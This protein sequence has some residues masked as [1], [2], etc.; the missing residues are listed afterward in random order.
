[1]ELPPLESY[2]IEAVEFI[3]SNIGKNINTLCALDVGMGKTRVACEILS[4][5]FYIKSKIRLQGYALVCCPTIGVIDSIWADT[6]TLYGLKIKILEGDELKIIKMEKSQRLT[7]APFTVCLI[8]YANII[9]GDNIDYLINYPPSIII[10]DEFHTLTNSSLDKNKKYRNTILKLPTKFK[11]GLTATPFVNNDMEAV[12]AFGILNDID[13][14]KIFQLANNTDKELL[15]R[16]VKY[17]KFLFY[18]E[19][20]Y[21]LTQ[22]SSELVISIPMGKE[23]FNQYLLIKNEMS[24]NKMS[25]L[26]QI[27][28]L[29]VSPKLISK[30]LKLQLNQSI[31]TGKIKALR[32]IISHLP[33]NDKIVICDNYRDTLKYIK[34]LDFIRPLKPVLYLGGAKSDNKKNIDLFNTKSDHKILLTT[35]QEG[36]EGLNLQVANHIVLMNCWYTVKDIIQII[37]RIKRKGQTKPVYAYIFGYNIFDCLE[38]GKDFQSYILKEDEDIY[39]IVRIKKE[40]YKEWRMSVETKLPPMKAFFNYYSFENDFNLFLDQIAFKEQPKITNNKFN[41]S[42]TYKSQKYFHEEDEEDEEE[43]EEINLETYSNSLLLQYDNYKKKDDDKTQNINGKKRITA[44]LKKHSDSPIL[45]HDND[46]EEEQ[47]YL[48]PKTAP[49]TA[50]QSDKPQDAQEG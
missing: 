11:I 40:I 22:G 48:T 49:Q 28:K 10:F 15:V 42:I 38:H 14:I 47:P 39:R 45:S 36:G 27:G 20:P 3:L 9:N 23:H 2:Q 7:I 13:L 43:E 19:N 17:K 46:E 30:P 41:N 37:G 24:S 18:K 12:Q 16:E 25:S 33:T 26:H 4:R 8:T 32:V 5:L 29:S 21:Q 1:M 35:R 6:L 50:S 34:M 44:K 31:E